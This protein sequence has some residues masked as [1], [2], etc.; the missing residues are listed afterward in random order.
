MDGCHED[1]TGNGGAD[2]VVVVCIA[3]AIFTDVVGL[4]EDD[5]KVGGRLQIRLF[6]GC[7][8]KLKVLHPFVTHSAIIVEVLLL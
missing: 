2:F 1:A 7:P 4:L 6:V 5:D 8:D 3:L